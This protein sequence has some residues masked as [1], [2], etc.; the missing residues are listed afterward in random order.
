M[1]KCKAK[2]YTEPESEAV[3]EQSGSSQTV[4][5]RTN[6]TVSLETINEGEFLTCES[7]MSDESERTRVSEKVEKCYGSNGRNKSND[8]RGMNKRKWTK[9][10]RL[11]LW[12]CFVRSKMVAPEGYIRSPVSLWETNG[13]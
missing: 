6:T 13:L 2:K 12:E 4:L 9:E 10:E 7:E 8:L 3:A 5:F 1:R 11:I